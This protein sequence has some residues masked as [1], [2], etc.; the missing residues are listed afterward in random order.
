MEPKFKLRNYSYVD[1]RGDLHENYQITE[2]DL[3]NDC[4]CRYKC[5]TFELENI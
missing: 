5:G 1:D 4:G 3:A 2:K